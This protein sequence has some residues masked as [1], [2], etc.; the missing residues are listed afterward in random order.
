MRNTGNTLK[1]VKTIA[2]LS[3]L[4]LFTAGI[5]AQD[6]GKVVKAVQD[7]YNT[8][9]DISADVKQASGGKN[10]FN[11]KVYFKKGNK[12]RAE[13]NNILLVSDG[14]TSWNY[15]KKENKVIIDRFDTSNPVSINSIVN[16]YPSRSD[17][18]ASSED[19]K[20]VLT[21]TPK[22]GSGL[23]FNQVKLWV[24]GNNLVDRIQVKQQSGNVLE[25]QISNYKLNQGTADSQFSFN[26]PH[27]A[28]VVDLR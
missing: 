25:L 8:S 23:N 15:N 17:V 21:L 6:A 1:Y 3:V 9:K 4:A 19:G 22:K 14:E 12:F 26:P 13:L 24:N 2:F 10:G 16:E 18:K 27:G 5:Y 7:K 28:K 11:G 20:T